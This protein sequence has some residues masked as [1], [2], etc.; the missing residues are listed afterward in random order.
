ERLGGQPVRPAVLRLQP[1]SLS[2]TVVARRGGEPGGAVERPA[3]AE[4]VVREPVGL[5]RV[6]RHGVPSVCATSGERRGRGDRLVMISRRTVRAG[7]MSRFKRRPAS[8]Y[9]H[10]L[11]GDGVE[12]VWTSRGDR[13]KIMA[14]PWVA[15]GCDETA[16]ASAEPGG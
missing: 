13:V 11:E 9:V 12:M 10:R 6:E 2:G 15:G 14:E 8:R 1:P 3:D 16:I 5:G 4:R 7:R